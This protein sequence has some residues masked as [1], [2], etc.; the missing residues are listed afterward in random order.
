[1]KPRTLLLFGSILQFSA[2]V[3]LSD[4]YDIN[5][6][7]GANMI[8]QATK[9]CRIAE[10]KAVELLNMSVGS[11]NGPPAGVE[12]IHDVYAPFPE[13]PIHDLTCHAE[14]SLING[15][16][17]SGSFSLH[18]P[19]RNDPLRVIWVSRDVSS[20]GEID[21][22]WDLLAQ[23]ALIKQYGKVRVDRYNSI[24]KGYDKC[25][26]DVSRSVTQ[27]YGSG[28]VINPSSPFWDAQLRRQN[29]LFAV[30][31]QAIGEKCGPRPPPISSPLYAPATW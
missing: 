9:N 2:G 22:A 25:L 29:D 19:G 6:E 4:G 24:Q 18:D 16:D 8:A 15:Q 20:Q 27:A 7:V 13:L 12:S 10:R 1:M 26:T 14:L 5:K 30:R 17:V 28:E 3:S 23:N 31:Q 21:D 11:P